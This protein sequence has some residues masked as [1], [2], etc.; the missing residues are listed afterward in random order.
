MSNDVENLVTSGA[1]VY[2]SQKMSIKFGLVICFVLSTFLLSND[3][4]LKIASMNA[5]SLV[6]M[7]MVCVFLLDG[8]IKGKFILLKHY[9]QWPLFLIFAWGLISLLISKIDPSKSIPDEVYSYA[10]TTGLN[11][12]LWRGLSFLFRLF[13]SIFAI[14]FMISNI[15][16]NKKYF[17]VINVI[18]L[19]Y[20][21]I[22]L[23]G[24]IQIVMFGIFDFQIGKII[25]TPGVDGYFRIGGY[26]GEPQ[27]FGLILAGGY[28]LV[29]A[30]IK[31]YKVL[32]FPKQLLKI[33]LI[34]AT[35]DL[36]FTFSV[37]MIV[38]VFLSFTLHV[39]KNIRPSRAA[40]LILGS[41]LL[42]AM[43]YDTLNT[44]IFSKLI[45]ELSSINER[46]IT[47]VIAHSIIIN[48]PFSGIGLGQSPLVNSVYIPD[49]IGSGFES[50]LFYDIVRQS[51]MNTYIEWTT[52][53][54]IVG[55]FI[56]IFLIYRIYKL[57]VK[58]I[59]SRESTFI[60]T[61]FGGSLLAISISFNSYSGGVYIGWVSLLI[62]MY[63][64]GFTLFGHPRSDYNP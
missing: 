53:T 18:L 29:L 9:I 26:V 12:P 25:L 34:L 13:L 14:E 63:V 35:I 3:D 59:S 30:S 50:I 33:V 56:L 46:T 52:E 51:P 62:A 22:C 2:K 28:F 60:Q 43:F 58:C 31:E 5:S 47:W 36:F 40:M 61:A 41:F 38:A 10:W 55:L 42:I 37:S 1:L 11:S 15:N 39:G 54:G 20:S 44:A 48:N 7:L 27:T 17:I 6:T 23:F 64:R 16:T 4:T 19:L 24:L 8:F 45:G 57:S 32:W 49:S 21:I